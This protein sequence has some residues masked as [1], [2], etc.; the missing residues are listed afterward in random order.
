[1]Y[2]SS[3]SELSFVGLSL[4]PLLLLLLLLFLLPLPRGNTSGCSMSPSTMSMRNN[5]ACFF[6]LGLTP[7]VHRVLKTVLGNMGDSSI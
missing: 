3:S 6:F 4:L 2:T 5:L 7:Q 1:M